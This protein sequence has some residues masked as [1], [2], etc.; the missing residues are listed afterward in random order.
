MDNSKNLVAPFT[1]RHARAGGHAARLAMLAALL[2]APVLVVPAA[3][4]AEVSVGITIA[5]PALPVYTQ[6]VAPAPGYI[7]T[8]GYWAWGPDGYYWVD[9]AWLLPPTVGMLWTPGWWGWSGGY[10]RWHPGYWGPQVGF[11]G[12]IDYGFG[13]FGD[14]YVG[15]N[16][17]GDH[18]Y[19]NRAVTNVNITNVRNVY[20]DKTVIHHTRN[21]RVSYNG[22]K[23]GRQA[24][25]STEQRAYAERRH[26]A[27]PPMTAERRDAAPSHGA[28]RPN[29]PLANQRPDTQRSRLDSPSRQEAAPRQTGRPQTAPDRAVAPRPANPGPSMNEE[30]GGRPQQ[31]RPSEAPRAAQPFREAPERPR[32]EARPAA[33]ERPRMDARPQ[34]F[35]PPRAEAPARHERQGAERPE[36]RG[37]GHSRQGRDDR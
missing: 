37:E 25:P 6:P 28:Q 16:W 14:G 13:Y 27:L 12:G 24:A 10:Y 2:S 5:P 20:V 29:A 34:E 18:F 1:R 8:P 23:G 36:R 17:R 30:R 26:Q 31:G 7:W 21:D 22:G 15:G 35:R 11:Y 4:L 3:A 19:Y 33:P 9:G 32:M